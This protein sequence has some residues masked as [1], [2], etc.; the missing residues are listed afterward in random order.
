MAALKSLLNLASGLTQSVFID[1]FFS[2]C[3][4][5]LLALFFVIVENDV[6]DHVL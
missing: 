6:F 3:T 5:F 4:L 2:F 1:C